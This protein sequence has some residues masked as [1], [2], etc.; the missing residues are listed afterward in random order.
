VLFGSAE[1]RRVKPDDV[2]GVL[3]AHP[4]VQH[5]R[6][7]HADLS[8]ELTIRTVRGQSVDLEALERALAALLGD[9]SLA[10]HEDAS[11]GDRTGKV[12]PYRS[13]LPFE[14]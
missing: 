8:L 13:D 9:V 14:E 12:A 1:G 6:G 7:Q 5:E 4:F 2:S 10:V 11:L 3:R